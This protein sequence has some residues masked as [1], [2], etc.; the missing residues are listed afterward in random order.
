M[1]G[2]AG[3]IGQSKKPKL[4]FNLL[5]ELFDHLETRGFDASGVWGTES[6]NDGRVI[7][8]KEPIKSSE[9]VKGEF[10]QDLGKVK[11]NMMLV[12]SRWKSRGGG[13]ARD[14]SNNHPFVSSDK[15]IGMVHNGT[16]DEFDYLKERYQILSDTDSEVLLRMFEHGIEEDSFDGRVQGFQ[17][18]WSLISEGAMAVAFGE[19]LENNRRFLYL[20]RNAKRP[21]WIAD[22]RKLLGQVF[23]FSSPE[24]WY[25]AI[26]GSP[27]LKNV[28]SG[29]Q[30]LIEVP[31]SQIW[32]FWIDDEHP[33]MTIQD[34]SPRYKVE[35][36]TEGESWSAGD[37]RKI[38][39]PQ[40]QLSVISQLDDDDKV[41][42]EV[43]KPKKIKG[44]VPYQEDGWEHDYC[45]E[46]D[47]TTTSTYEQSDELYDTEIETEELDFSVY[48]TPSN[49]FADHEELC[50]QI[51]DLTNSVETSASN[52]VMQ[53][54]FSKSDYQD[55]L[56]TLEQT[57]VDLE[58][59]LRLA[60]TELF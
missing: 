48:E 15:R 10:W 6:G 46:S 35:V 19:R 50:R 27:E 53:G 54:S 51:V 30:N 9:F 21:L 3:Y 2:I 16:L 52:S 1:C 5:T 11:T 44:K 32:G 22:L 58:G 49:G 14:N 4:S 45:V 33:M 25:R 12:H 37:V 55:L 36:S 31:T 17:E 59:T 57:R 56:N 20:F 18:I 13:L 42:G 7:Y 47:G 23:F 40:V 41:L 26:A 60:S 38:K 39:K 8:H 43:T 34:Q 29:T 24:I 28:C